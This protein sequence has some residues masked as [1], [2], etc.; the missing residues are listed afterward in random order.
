MFKSLKLIKIYAR[1]WLILTLVE[2]AY[3][4]G[5]VIYDPPSSPEE[6]ISSG[7]LLFGLLIIGFM[8]AVAAVALQ[9][10]RRWL[11]VISVILLGMNP[12]L[13][14]LPISS[15]VFWVLSPVNITVMCFVLYSLSS[16]SSS[17]H[18]RRG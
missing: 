9:T 3:V 17:S 5:L 6:N 18:P 8:S 4:I 10:N 7:L 13:F 1:F 15:S 16:N 12:I 14:I 2:F 11:Q